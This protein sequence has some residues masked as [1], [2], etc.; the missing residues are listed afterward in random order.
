M[1]QH[2]LSRITEIWQPSINEMC[3]NKAKRLPV[4]NLAKICAVLNCG[5][6]DIM[7]LVKEPTD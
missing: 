3:N 2:E 1:S 5:I 6:T 7:E 4:D